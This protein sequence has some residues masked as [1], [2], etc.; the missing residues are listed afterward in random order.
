M[1]GLEALPDSDEQL[2]DDGRLCAS[3]VLLYGRATH[4]PADDRSLFLAR[5]SNLL[6]L[7]GSL[8]PS[9]LVL[10]VTCRMQ[11]TVSELRCS[12]Y[13]KI[14]ADV[15]DNDDPRPQVT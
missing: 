2:L 12:A 8:T 13:S 1:D 11:H 4:Q 10:Y 9:Y 15:L 7:L 14:K 5:I 3:L 6:L